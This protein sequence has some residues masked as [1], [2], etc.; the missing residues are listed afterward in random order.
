V[1]CFFGTY[2]VDET[3]KTKTIH[4]E[5]CTFPQWDEID[6]TD[7]IAM[8]TENELIVTTTKPIPDPT[9]GAFV[10]HIKALKS[11]RQPYESRLGYV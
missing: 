10:P 3:A 5:G 11:D 8:P 9:M 7:N 4:I 6:A 1:S 2:T